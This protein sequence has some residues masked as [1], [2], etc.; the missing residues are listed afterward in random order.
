[1]TGQSVWQYFAYLRL[2]SKNLFQ[3]FLVFLL[4]Q[5]LHPERY[6][7]QKRQGLSYK[8]DGNYQNQIE[9]Q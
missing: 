9:D 3:P 8:V 7:V 2:A 4:F 5:A 6:Q 1:M